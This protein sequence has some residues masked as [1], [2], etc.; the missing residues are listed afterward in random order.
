MM[1]MSP[2]VGLR[3]RQSVAALFQILLFGGAWGLA[4]GVRFDFQ[5]PPHYEDLLLA[6]WGIAALVKGFAFLVFRLHRHWWRY[7][8]VRDLEAIIKSVVASFGLLL[9]IFFLL[10]PGEGL[11]VPRGIFVLDLLLSVFFLGGL[12][13][14]GR[15]SRGRITGL[16]AGRDRQRI[17]IF[18]AG[19]S[20]E[21]LMREIDR[22]PSMQQRVVALFDDDVALRG[23]RVQGV[24]VVGPT[25]DFAPFAAVRTVDEVVIATPRASG[26]DI[27]RMV[28]VCRRAGTPAR[29]LPAIGDLLDGRVSWSKLREVDIHD[30]LGRKPVEL[31][32]EVVSGLLEGKTVL[33]TGGGGSIGS[34]LVRQ[35]AAW[36]PRRILA[37]DQS[38]NPIFEL[39]KSLKTHG[40]TTPVVPIIADVCDRAR[41]EAVFRKW[42]PQ[43][44][45]HAAA[46]KH[47]PLMEENPAEAVHNNVFGTRNVAR[48]AG[49]FESTHFV[50]IST[51]KA[52]NP[53]SVMG[54]T[55]RLAEL[56]VQEMTAAHPKTRFVS[57]RFGNVLG[58]NGSVVP[59]FKEQIARGGP[60]TVTH[61][62]MMRYFMTIP[63]ASQLVLEAAGLGEGGEVFILDMGEPIR[64]VDMARELI[65]LSGLE[66][67]EDIKIEFTGTRPGEKLFEELS[68]EG[69]GAQKTHHPK[70]FVGTVRRLDPKLLES[71]LLRM[72]AIVFFGGLLDR[73]RCCGR[74]GDGRWGRR[75]RSC[76]GSLRCDGRGGDVATEAVVS[77]RIDRDTCLIGDFRV[78]DLAKELQVRGD[79]RT[80]RAPAGARLGLLLRRLDVQGATLAGHC[81]RGDSRQASNLCVGHLAEHILVGGELLGGR[82]GAVAIGLLGRRGASPS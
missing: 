24:A 5:V 42:M 54:A 12:R 56:I 71:G 26:A 67:D 20:A 51:D 82:P 49:Q 47:V 55:K 17:A 65:R 59:I 15:V 36:A 76:S 10:D 41:M 58:S 63:E 66:P 30:I 79:A 29:V 80:P 11:S 57:V 27:Q 77:H 60:V 53:T 13:L 3:A 25:E 61:P 16:L 19:D 14:L 45:L 78:W 33:I 23:T 64:I 6:T 31:D 62:D 43:V 68:L 18:G 4:F 34:E 21:Q 2:R 8:G 37:L 72:E 35:I 81:L 70:V 22:N 73:G 44:V 38:E 32:S 69:E 74:R 40:I 46:H 75:D 52:V 9:I 48:L 39:Q 50:M 1:E 7:A 28:A